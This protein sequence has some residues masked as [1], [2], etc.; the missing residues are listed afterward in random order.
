LFQEHQP[1][2]IAEMP[3]Q[4][5][6]CCPAK[7]PRFSLATIFIGLIHG[8]YGPDRPVRLAHRGG[9]TLGGMSVA[10]TGWLSS[11]KPIGGPPAKSCFIPQ[12]GTASPSPFGTLFMSNAQ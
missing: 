7:D 3:R 11:R 10:G 6:S 9:F 12:I 1:E 4:G 5:P 8:R 2:K